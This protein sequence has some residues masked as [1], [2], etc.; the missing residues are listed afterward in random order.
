MSTIEQKRSELT[1]AVEKT[2]IDFCRVQRK[3][4][5]FGPVPT[6]EVI[7]VFARAMGQ[8]ATPVA[9]FKLSVQQGGFALGASRLCGMPDFPKDLGWPS[10]DGVPLAFLAQIDLTRLPEGVRWPVPREGWI[11]IFLGGDQAAWQS[12]ATVAPHRVIY[13]GGPANALAPRSAPPGVVVPPGMQHAVPYDLS[14][15]F[16]WSAPA[17]NLEPWKTVW[18]SLVH[19]S[20]SSTLADVLRPLIEDKRSCLFRHFMLDQFM[21][22]PRPLA[23][24]KATGSPP[25]RDAKDWFPLFSL[26]STLHGSSGRGDGIWH[27]VWWDGFALQVFVD[28]TRSVLGD[29]SK[30][31]VLIL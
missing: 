23:A 17:T 13:F 29:F 2:W 25:P 27:F 9:N 26:N 24:A 15:A 22:D 10:Q 4:V 28:R 14:F 31:S 3:N 11:Y 6:D 16:G 18:T 12:N 1:N 19:D 5:K 7:R 30:T 8:A 20:E 21:G